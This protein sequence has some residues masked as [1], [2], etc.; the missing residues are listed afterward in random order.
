MAGLL[1]QK[2]QPL[3]PGTP[4]LNSSEIQTL[5]QQLDDWQVADDEKSMQRD[6]IFKNY[7]QTMA[8]VNAVAWIAHNEDH[9]PD[10]LVTYNRCSITYSTHS[11]GGLSLND[12]IC[13]A[14]IDKLRI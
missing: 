3:A 5:Q 12:F 10:L 14:K 13:A 1:Q 2:S 11:I 6:F 9:H 8:F 4:P 7:Y